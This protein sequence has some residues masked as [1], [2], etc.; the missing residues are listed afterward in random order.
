MIVVTGGRR[1]EVRREAAPRPGVHRIQ[2]DGETLEIAIDEAAPPRYR[3]RVGGRDELVYC[4]AEG[5]AIHLFW[6]GRAYR[7]DRAAATARRSSVPTGTLESPMPGR[8]LEVK[9]KP[10]DAVV[11][12]Q[13]LIVVEAM[14]MENIVRAPR[15]GRIRAVAVAVDARVASGQTLIELE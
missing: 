4:I 5:D 15:D 2:V 13:P 14:K 8:V 6:R 12:G 11:K 9:V 7:L 3:V 10:G 1:R